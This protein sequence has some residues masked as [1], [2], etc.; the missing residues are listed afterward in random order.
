MANSYHSPSRHTLEDVA[1]ARPLL[2]FVPLELGEIPL[3]VLQLARVQED[4]RF[5]DD[6]LTLH[7]A[8][9]SR[10]VARLDQQLGPHNPSVILAALEEVEPVQVR[11]GDATHDRSADVVLG[12]LHHA[13]IVGPPDAAPAVAMEDRWSEAVALTNVCWWALVVVADGEEDL[14]LHLWREHTSFVMLAS[15]PLFLGCWP[16]D[17]ALSHRPPTN[18]KVGCPGLSYQSAYNW[19]LAWNNSSPELRI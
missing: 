8:V 12:V 4:V 1:S 16:V 13:W 15:S 9:T 14:R 11:L 3:L 19:L 17:L 2:Q 18:A 6:L 10:L 7:V 5:S